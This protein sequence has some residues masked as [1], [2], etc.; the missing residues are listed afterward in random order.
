MD[1]RTYDRPAMLL[2]LKIQEQRVIPTLPDEVLA[3]VG[4]A[5]RIIGPGL[6]RA[7]EA[8]EDTRSITLFDICTSVARYGFAEPVQDLVTTKSVRYHSRSPNKALIATTVLGVACG[9]LSAVTLGLGIIQNRGR[10]LRTLAG[11]FG[12]RHSARCRLRR[13]FASLAR[14]MSGLTWSCRR[15]RLRREPP[16]VCEDKKESDELLVKEKEARPLLVVM[17]ASSGI[18]R[19]FP[20]EGQGGNEQLCSSM[21]RLRREWSPI[22]EDEKV[23]NEISVEEKDE[24]ESDEISVEENDKEELDEI[25]PEEEEARRRYPEGLEKLRQ[26]SP[27]NTPRQ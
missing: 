12:M 14:R 19:K 3:T 15:K 16:S 11:L 1:S 5:C 22:C 24:E 7:L 2:A 8:L 27:L 21:K 9:A 23:S 6:F 25:S 18:K 17:E 10:I 13:T 4:E 26:L 20:S